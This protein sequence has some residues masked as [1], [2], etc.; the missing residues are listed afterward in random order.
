MSEESAPVFPTR[1]PRGVPLFQR[2][3]DGRLTCLPQ[4]CARAPRSRLEPLEPLVLFPNPQELIPTLVET[5]VVIHDLE[6]A[7]KTEID[8]CEPEHGGRLEIRVCAQPF[9]ESQGAGDLLTAW[10]P[11]DFLAFAL[12]LAAHKG[13]DYVPLEHQPWR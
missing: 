5:H 8:A 7:R 2:V 4:A 1:R 12:L 6:G 10:D 3:G 9:P 13:L 11:P